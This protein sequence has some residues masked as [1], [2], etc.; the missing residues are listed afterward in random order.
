MIQKGATVKINYTLSVDGEIVD[1]SYNRG[2]PLTYVQGAGQ[3]IPELERELEGLK[4]GDSREVVLPPE[5]AYGLRDPEAIQ[6]VSKSAFQD[7]EQLRVGGMVQ[8]RTSEG[9]AFQ[10]SIVELNEEE[11]TLDLNH[12]LAG[13]T[14]HF[15]VE[16]VG[17]EE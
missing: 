14:L 11:V 7:P 15:Q 5:K 9:T 8:G 16:V 3:I 13:K 10:A 17:V 12:P 1:S 6:Q 4:E 2:E